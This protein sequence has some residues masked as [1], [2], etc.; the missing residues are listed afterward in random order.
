MP[1]DPSATAIHGQNIGTCFSKRRGGFRD[2]FGWEPEKEVFP[3][4]FLLKEAV[5][6]WFLLLFLLAKRP[7]AF[8]GTAPHLGVWV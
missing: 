1:A 4:N 8:P 3:T 6:T 5:L 7:V 2:L